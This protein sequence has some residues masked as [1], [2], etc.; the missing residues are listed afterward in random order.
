MNLDRQTLLDAIGRVLSAEGLAA[1]AVD[2]GVRSFGAMQ[3]RTPAVL[4]F[5][6]LNEWQP[7]ALLRGKIIEQRLRQALLEDPGVRV[8][9]V[10]WRIGSDVETPFDHQD[11]IGAR[12]TRE[13]LTQ[14]HTQAQARGAALGCDA[15]VTDWAGLPATDVG[16]FDPAPPRH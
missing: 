4:V 5:I 1:A 10:Y 11:R 16:D 9:Y 6:R 14:L 2:V 3:A 7:Q 12:P 15:P 13:R 8:G